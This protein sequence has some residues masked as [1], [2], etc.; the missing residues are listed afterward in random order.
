MSRIDPATCEVLRE[1]NYLG[2]IRDAVYG[3]LAA[4]DYDAVLAIHG[5]LLDQ[6]SRL[7][8][9]KYHAT[10]GPTRLYFASARRDTL[11]IAHEIEDAARIAASRIAKKEE[12]A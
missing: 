7:F 3:M 6:A 1:A 4:G 11:D 12:R 5:S 9:E 8:D 10:N 2:A